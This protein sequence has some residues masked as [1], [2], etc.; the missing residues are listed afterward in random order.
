[1]DKIGFGCGFFK[2][3][4]LN[5]CKTVLMLL[6]PILA[7]HF[8]TPP[9]AIAQNKYEKSI[10]VSININSKWDYLEGNYRVAGFY[11]SNIKGTANLLEEKG[12][13]LRYSSANLTA[14]YEFK[15]DHIDMSSDSPCFKKIVEKN[16]GSGSGQVKDFI[17]DIFLGQAGK[18]AWLASHG[19]APTPEELKIPKDVYQV[20]L[21]AE[22]RFTAQRKSEK[23]CEP[24]NPT[25]I[26]F[27]IGFTVGIAEVKPW[28]STESHAWQGDI[29]YK[30]EKVILIVPSPAPSRAAQYQVSWTLGET[31]PVVRIYREEEDITDKKYE[32]VIVGQRV[33]LKAEVFPEGFGTPQGKWEI[34]GKIVS[35]WDAD[36]NQAVLKNFEEYQKPEIEFFW[37]DGEFAGSPQIVKYSG[38]V[39]GKDVQAKTTFHVFKPEIKSERIDLAKMI[40][41]GLEP[42]KGKEGGELLCTVHAGHYEPPLPNPPGILISH[43]IEMPPLNEGISHR[44]QH[45]Q[46]V[47]DDSLHHHNVNYF[48]KRNDQWCLDT[49]YP[50]N[51]RAEF[52]IDLDDTPGAPLGKLTWEYHNQNEFQTYLMFIPSSNPQDENAIWVPLRLIEWEWAVGVE[53]G[54]DLPRD[55]PCNKT[56]YK[57]I[58]EVPPRVIGKESSPDYPEWSCNAKNNKDEVIGSERHDEDWKRLTAE[59]EKRWK[60]K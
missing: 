29:K 43:E 56:T 26:T 41:V 1:M 4:K 58:Y 8:F 57:P 24:T 34:G 49:T 15:E 5:L 32:D 22:G 38:Q 27:P 16:D 25:S 53:K 48:R 2:G 18:F 10:P 21:A 54:K 28:G 47:K 6:A 52:R 12:E 51:G 9:Q 35:G 55:A 46:L 36:E 23:G 37:V 14:F 33:K 60:G 42:S 59:R 19:Q 20:T 3:N 39:E 44:L 31:K 40:T 45:V 11:K 13:F 50:Y 17:L 30:D 7:C